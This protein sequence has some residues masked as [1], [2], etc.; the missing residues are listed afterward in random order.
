MTTTKTK[1][2]NDEHGRVSCAC[3]YREEVRSASGQTL[4]GWRCPCCTKQ[5]QRICCDDCSKPAIFVARLNRTNHVC[6]RC[7]KVRRAKALA[8][9]EAAP[10]SFAAT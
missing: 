7:K 1:K 3:V 8:K 5:W 10:S 6:S 9:P 4:Y 2:S